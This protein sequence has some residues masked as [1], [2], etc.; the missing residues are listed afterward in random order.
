M[1]RIDPALADAMDEYA[2][3]AVAEAPP[4]TEEQV[5]QLRAALRNPG[6]P[7]TDES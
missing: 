6:G 4:L 7:T 2:D 5:R 1:A 3:E